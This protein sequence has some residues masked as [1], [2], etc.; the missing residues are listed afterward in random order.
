MGTEHFIP[1]SVLYTGT[2]VS[3]ASRL[4]DSD[5]SDY[6][7]VDGVVRFSFDFSTLPQNIKINR[8]QLN[9]YVYR[10]SSSSYQRVYFYNKSVGTTALSDGTLDFSASYQTK[11]TVIVEFPKLV[12]DINSDMSLLTEN[13]L[14]LSLAVS[15]SSYRVYSVQLQIDYTENITVLTESSPSEGGTV[16]GGGTYEIGS[17]V[18][19]TAKTNDGYTFSH[20]LIN[21]VDSGVTEPTISGTLMEDTI[22]TAVF[23]KIET[24]KIYC[25]TKK[26]SVYCGTKKVSVYCGTK[27]LT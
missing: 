9:L 25:G 16:T 2:G 12:S 5:T 17:T 7:T 1:T 27:K 6:A 23:E 26:V 11:Q 21:G 4:L 15:S 3:N 8:V 14:A 20:W 24:S 18:T 19:A 22:V 10:Y 13:K